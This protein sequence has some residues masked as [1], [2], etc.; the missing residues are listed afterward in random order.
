MEP[1]RAGGVATFVA[2]PDG[3]GCVAVIDAGDDA[4]DCG[5]DGATQS[6]VLCLAEIADRLGG[7]GGQSEPETDERGGIGW[8]GLD[9]GVNGP[10]AGDGG[11]AP[12]LLETAAGC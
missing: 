8:D 12:G 9:W 5:G 7:A 10:Q 3:S 1:V 11:V 4:R 6:G 2:E